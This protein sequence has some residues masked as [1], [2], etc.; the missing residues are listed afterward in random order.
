MN[1]IIGVLNDKQRYEMIQKARMNYQIKFMDNPDIRILQDRINRISIYNKDTL[2][3][4]ITLAIVPL[5]ISTEAI[6]GFSGENTKISLNLIFEEL[7]RIKT[8]LKYI[9]DNPGIEKNKQQKMNDLISR[10]IL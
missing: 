3:H 9:I 7:D 6:Q 10:I 4:T 2:I 8:K 5:H 1:H